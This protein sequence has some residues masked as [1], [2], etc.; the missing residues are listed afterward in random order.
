M[1]DKITSAHPI[2]ASE[3]TVALAANADVTCLLSNLKQFVE[4]EE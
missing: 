2:K 1:I 3:P 4:L